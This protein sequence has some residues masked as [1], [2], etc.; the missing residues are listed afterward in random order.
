MNIFALEVFND[1]GLAC[2]LYTV[3][4]VD[5]ELSETD[6][7]FEKFNNSARLK[8]CVQEL[9]VLISDKIADQIGAVEA[10]FRYENHAQALPPQGNR[11]VQNIYLKYSDFP[12][13]LYCLRLSDQLLILFNGAEKTTSSA[14]KGETSMAF[15]E[16]NHFSKRI[17]EALKQ[18]DIYISDNGR[19]ILDLNES[20]SITI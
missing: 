18:K 3:R 14:Q 10:L 4:W 7:F 9:A 15:Q 6:K 1:E 16:A 19:V 20:L 5:S 13:R 17:I 8:S 2:T 11:T 12:L